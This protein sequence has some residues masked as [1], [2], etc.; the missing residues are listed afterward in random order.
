VAGW[1][2]AAA[3]VPAMP[4]WGLALIT[5]GG[6]WICVWQ[7]RWRLLGAAPIVLGVASIWLT[8]PPD[9]LVSGDGRLMGVRDG[10]GGLLLSSARA[11][12]F[13]AEGWLRRLGD[14]AAETWPALGS[15]ADGSLSCDALGCIYR[16]GG[17][18]VALVK[19][20]A[21]LDEDCR[22]AD[23]VVSLVPVRRACP[24]AGTVIDRFDLWREGAHAL[25]LTPET[26]EVVSVGETRGDRPWV[27]RPAGVKRE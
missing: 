26:V 18:A 8:A 13:T 22:V 15:T 1:P 3:L 20:M 11:E 5:G 14:D 4:L 7:R 17:H 16:N 24:S 25:W 19:Q 27:V 9:V 21:A 6:L 2:G 10:T 12:A 23:V